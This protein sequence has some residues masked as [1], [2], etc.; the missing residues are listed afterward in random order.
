MRQSERNECIMENISKEY[1]ILFN[2]ITDAEHGLERM[3]KKLIR[4]QQQAEELFIERDENE[5]D[6]SSDAGGPLTDKTT[7]A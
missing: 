1:L 2:A 5:Q 3:R 4:V 7:P 6:P